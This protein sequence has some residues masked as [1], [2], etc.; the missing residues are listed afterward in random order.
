[1]WLASLFS[2]N[3]LSGN[4]RLRIIWDESSLTYQLNTRQ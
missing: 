2:I 4:R 1:M 3:Q